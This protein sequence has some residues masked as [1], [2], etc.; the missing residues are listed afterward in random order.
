M[1]RIM[2]QLPRADWSGEWKLN[3][4]TNTEKIARLAMLPKGDSVQFEFPDYDPEEYPDDPRYFPLDTTGLHYLDF[5]NDGDLDL[6]YSGASGWLTLR[7]TKVF[8]FEN[9]QYRLAKVLEG[10][11]LDIHKTNGGFEVYT[12][13]VPC[14]GSYTTRIEKHILS[15]TELATFNE[16]ISIIGLINIKGMSN[17]S[18]LKSAWVE[19]VDLMSSSMDFR[20]FHPHFRSNKKQMIED[21]RSGKFVSLMP[22]TD[23][24]NVKVITEKEV[25]NQKWYLIITEAFQAPKSHYEWSDGPGRRFVGWVN[26]INLN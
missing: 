10:R 15:P 24:T 1:G 2:S 8:V 21:M 16:S 26:Q 13:W 12:Q 20:G 23:R 9:G 17:F 22:L 6:L 25:N 19:A 18:D 5:D 11:I 4:L 7:S 14:C 3:Q